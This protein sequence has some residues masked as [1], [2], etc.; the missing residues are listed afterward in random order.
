MPREEVEWFFQSVAKAAKDP[1]T[2]LAPRFEVELNAILAYRQSRASVDWKSSSPQFVSL[3]LTTPTLPEIM[4]APGT[5]LTEF[6]LFASPWLET[7]RWGG[8]KADVLFFTEDRRHVVLIEG[9]VDSYFTYGD[10]PPD[11]Q[12]WRQLEFLASLKHDTKTLVLLCPRFN[13]NWY[14]S[15]LTRAW[16]YRA[17]PGRVFACLVP[18]EDLFHINAS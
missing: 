1:V 5:T 18:W 4:G 7:D 16:E 6:P 8:M 13:L 3:P 15:R 17:L 14:M 12:L 10:Y 11:E 2:N 9:K